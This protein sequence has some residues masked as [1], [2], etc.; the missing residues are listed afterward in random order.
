MEGLLLMFII[1]LKITFITR[2][3]PIPS[4][5]S[6]TLHF[7]T[8]LGNNTNLV[9][10]IYSNSSKN[11]NQKI[12]FSFLTA[13]IEEYFSKFQ[14]LNIRNKNG[15][16]MELMSDLLKLTPVR[17]SILGAVKKTL[18]SSEFTQEDFEKFQN[19]FNLTINKID[20][21]AQQ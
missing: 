9:D 21:E 15:Q 13:L 1:I 5:D 12:D 17:N 18:Q 19:G 4:S 3:I 7:E 10:L 20:V 16:N 14:E 6:D 11:L 8:N 2:G